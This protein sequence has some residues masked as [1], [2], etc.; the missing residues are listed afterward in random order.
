MAIKLQAEFSDRYELK[1]VFANTGQEHEETLKFL[2][3][4]DRKFNL[5]VVWLEAV[6][7]PEKNKGTTHKI[8]TFETA[9]RK[10]EPFEDMIKVYGIPN[11]SYPHCNRELKICAMNSYIN[12]IGW[13]HEFRAIGIR[14][15][16]DN[17]ACDNAGKERKLYPLIDFFPT[18]KQ[19]VL[20]WFDGKD[21]DLN[22][23]EHLGNCV[24][25]W[26]KSRPKLINIIRSEPERFEFFDRM[27]KEHGLSG[28]NKDGT[29][30]VFFRGNTSVDNLRAEEY[31]MP[32]LDFG[33]L[34]RCANEECGLE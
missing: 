1:F 10:G 15:D 14:C 26:K 20:D 17:R 21:Y 29:E 7:N 32:E 18:D 5:D 9:S 33:N 28:S 4:I 3:R 25:C 12:S 23:Q 2:D 6:I 31:A 19:D 11:P 13:K 16:E 24:T 30:R 27:E 34:D 22:I 8:V